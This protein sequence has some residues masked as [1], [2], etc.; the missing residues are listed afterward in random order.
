[1]KIAFSQ[2]WPG[3]EGEP[4]FFYRFLEAEGFNPQLVVDQNG[5][6]DLEFVSVFPQRR[7]LIARKVKSMIQRSAMGGSE[8]ALANTIDTLP[9]RRGRTRVW[10]TGENIR[11]PFGQDFDYSLSYEQDSYESNNVYLPLWY[12]HLDW[13]GKPEFNHR[14]GEDVSSSNLL[15]PR[16]MASSKRKLACAFIGNPHPMRSRAIEAL[17]RSGVVDVFGNS[18]GKPVQYKADVAKDYK[19]MI[20]FENDLYPGYVTEKLLDA[21][22]SGTVPFYWGDLGNDQHVNRQCFLNLS[23][24]S[25][26]EDAVSHLSAIDDEQYNSIFNQP[27]LKSKPSLAAFVELVGSV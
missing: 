27:F 10:F 25:S 11:V 2:F 23:D 16:Q 8:Q 15:N 21:Y 19:Y 20:C 26:L 24:F 18:V 7:D 22:L 5:K 17:S 13:F 9:P 12:T 6:C 3:F 1:M 14:V 4:S